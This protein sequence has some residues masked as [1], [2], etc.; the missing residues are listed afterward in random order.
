MLKRLL[1]FA[2][3]LPLVGGCASPP[4]RPAMTLD[5]PAN[6]NAVEAPLPPPSTTL[7]PDHLANTQPKPASMNGMSM[8]GMTGMNGMKGMGGNMNGM[9]MKPQHQSVPGMHQNPTTGRSQ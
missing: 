4:P 5:N 6:P 3:A 2:F 9:D 7:G 8:N 1:L